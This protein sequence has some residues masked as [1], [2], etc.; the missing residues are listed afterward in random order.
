MRV[1]ARV[2]AAALMTGA[3]AAALAFPALFQPGRERHRVLLAPPSSLQR[4]LR[5]PA[6]RTPAHHVARHAE[7]RVSVNRGQARTGRSPAAFARVVV[8]RAK[9]VPP[10]PRPAPSAPPPATPSKPSAPPPAAA[11]PRE[12]A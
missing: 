2:L 3:V 11:P 7:A 1:Y 6:V 4:T 9:A 10:A 12:L 5:V 8:H